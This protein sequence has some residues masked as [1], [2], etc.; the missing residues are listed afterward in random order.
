MDR[1]CVEH[2]K[3]FQNPPYLV[4]QI[5][6]MIS[7]MIG[8]K[9]LTE[10]TNRSDGG[11]TIVSGKEAATGQS[12]KEKEKEETTTGKVKSTMTI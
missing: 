8:K 1:A 11:T 2:V 4:G 5:M 12:A 6:E 10:I 7:V 9:K 3:G